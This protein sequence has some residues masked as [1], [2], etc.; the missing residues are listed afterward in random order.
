L[1]VAREVLGFP[2]ASPTSCPKLLLVRADG[3]E[4]ALLFDAVEGTRELVIKP[5]GPLLV[6]HPVI[7]GTSLSLTGD[8]ILVLKPS[9]LSQWICE[10]STPAM[11]RPEQEPAP[12]LGPVLV[13]DDSISVR[14]VVTRRLRS[15]GLEVEEVSD[16]I[17]ALSKLSSRPYGVVLTDLE[18][19]RMDGFELLAEMRRLPA[20]AS[21]PVI[22]A[23]TE[24]QAATRRR[25]L[26]LGARAFLSKPIDQ[27][28][29]ARVVGTLL[30]GAMGVP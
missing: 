27:T 6:G 24:S 3:K 2:S 7:W 19:P 10:E 9:G 16:G 1:I 13:V 11:V 12:R 25:A 26:A 29:L 17:E 14:R 23:S 28:E 21:V 8:V 5:L 15:L 18:M 4:L 22:V 20:L 30:T